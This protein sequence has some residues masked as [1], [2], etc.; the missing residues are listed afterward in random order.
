[1]F[2]SPGATLSVLCQLWTCATGPPCLSVCLSLTGLCN[3][4]SWQKCLGMA[5]AVHGARVFHC[6]KLPVLVWW[7]AL[8]SFC[9]L[10]EPL[11]AVLGLAMCHSHACLLLL[12]QQM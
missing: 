7:A 3:A 12:C 4:A 9:L 6:E 11:K 1:M 10:Q 2:V 5:A 8:G